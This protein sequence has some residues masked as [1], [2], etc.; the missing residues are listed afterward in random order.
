MENDS[1]KQEL[2]DAGL[3]LERLERLEELAEDAAWDLFDQYDYDPDEPEEAVELLR[4]ATLE[5]ILWADE[6]IDTPKEESLNMLLEEFEP[7]DDGSTEKARSNL[8][9]LL[10][11]NSKEHR[12]LLMLSNEVMRENYEQAGGI[13][14]E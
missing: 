7:G 6:M 5:H 2:V 8:M 3:S 9:V 10:G 14:H 4:Q 12:D 1:P 11:K 13:S